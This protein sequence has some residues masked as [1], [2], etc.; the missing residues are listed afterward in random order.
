[1]QILREIYPELPTPSCLTRWHDSSSTDGDAVNPD[2]LSSH[3]KQIVADLCALTKAVRAIKMSWQ[4]HCKICNIS[5]ANGSVAAHIAG[6][7]H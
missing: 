1:M 5:C 7:K 3:S 4:S 2:L 6:N